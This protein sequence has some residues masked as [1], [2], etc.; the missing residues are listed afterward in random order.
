MGQG[1]Q[2]WNSLGTLAT[3]PVL[4]AAED[5][6]PGAQDVVPPSAPVG[7]AEDLQDVPLWRPSRVPC[8]C[9][10]RPELSGSAWEGLGDGQIC[11]DVFEAL[12]LL[13]MGMGRTGLPVNPGSLVYTG[14]S[15]CNECGLKT[16]V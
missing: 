3:G 12:G 14:I 4:R 15:D 1:G 2:L 13:E 11:V 10:L 6:G 9:S 5:S 16:P 8:F 7:L